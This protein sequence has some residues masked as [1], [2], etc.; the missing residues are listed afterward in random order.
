MRSKNPFQRLL[1]SLLLAIFLISCQIPFMQWLNRSLNSDTDPLMIALEKMRDSSAIPLEVT[2]ESGFP[3]SVIGALPA[4]GGDALTQALNFLNTYSDLYH[5]NDPESEL[6]LRR[7][8]ENVSMKHIVFHQ[9]Y[10]TLPVYASQLVVSLQGSM[11]AGSAGNLLYDIMI[12]TTPALSA[13]Q[14]ENAARE[15]LEM[16]AEIK[17][18]GQ[19][20]LVIFDPHL[21]DNSQQGMLACPG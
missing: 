14:A 10:K 3:V 12:D 9:T 11:V 2:F 13:I 16:P 21:L 17:M 5:L 4:G 18:I 1:C 6:R 7:V 8:E 15:A 19:P 20:T